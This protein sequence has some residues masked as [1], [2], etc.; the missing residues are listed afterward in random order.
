MGS[1]EVTAEATERRGAQ[2]ESRGTSCEIRNLGMA[3]LRLERSSGSHH[4]AEGVFGADPEF[5]LLRWSANGAA[6][7]AD[8]PRAPPHAARDPRL[9]SPSFTSPTQPE[10]EFSIEIPCSANELNDL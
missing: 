10:G 2:P 9:P 6:E 3:R 4:A 1:G 5:T 8:S 7:A